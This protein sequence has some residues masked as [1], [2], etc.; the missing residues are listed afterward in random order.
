MN[1]FFLALV[2]S[3]GITEGMTAAEITHGIAALSKSGM[4]GGLAKIA[5]VSWLK[6]AFTA[7]A[8][9]TVVFGVGSF[10]YREQIKR[11]FTKAVN[12]YRRDHKNNPTE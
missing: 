10:L 5:Q 3:M 1:K 8:V 2:N 4:I 12:E 7:G 6:G 11:E 9:V